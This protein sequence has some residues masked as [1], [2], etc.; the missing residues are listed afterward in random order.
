MNRIERN[1]GVL[2]TVTSKIKH[3][4]HQLGSDYEE[5]LLLIT[6]LELIVRAEKS[7]HYEAFFS[8]ISLA[9]ELLSFYNRMDFNDKVAVNIISLI[10]NMIKRYGLPPTDELFEFFY[11]LRMI[12]KVNYYVS[13]FITQFPQFHSLSDKWDYLL[14]IPNIAPKL[15]SERNFYIEMKKIIDSGEGIPYDY[16]DKVICIFNEFIKGA[17][18]NFYPDDYKKIIYDIEMAV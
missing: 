1:I 5:M 16:R 11:N 10:G 18:N 12:K 17:K 8:D 13:L 6:K 9:N 2:N 14:S 3:H 4:S 15:K 7:S